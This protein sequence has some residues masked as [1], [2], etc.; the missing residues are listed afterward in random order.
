[1]LKPDGLPAQAKPLVTAVWAV[2]VFREFRS[3]SWRAIALLAVTF[4]FYLGAI[5][6]L[7]GSVRQVRGL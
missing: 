7:A 6:L 2:L 1:M 5:G 3:S 4:G